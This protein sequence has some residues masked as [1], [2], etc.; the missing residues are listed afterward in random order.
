V[1]N[2]SEDRELG[3]EMTAEGWITIGGDDIMWMHPPSQRCVVVDASTRDTCD[4]PCWGPEPPDPKTNGYFV[5]CRVHGEGGDPL[6]GD[7]FWVE[8]YAVAIRVARNI[9]SA[10][11]AETLSQARDRKAEFER[12]KGDGD[13]ALMILSAGNAKATG[14]T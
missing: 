1:G 13:I 11:L 12:R 5:A 10:I 8:G 3:P 6:Y 14:A 9:R 7:A 2:V 4:V